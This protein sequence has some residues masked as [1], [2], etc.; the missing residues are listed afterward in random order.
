MVLLIDDKPD[1][2]AFAVTVD[3]VARSY[4][5]GISALQERRWDLLLLDH[6]LG[7]FDEQG[8][9]YTGHSIATW[10]EENPRYLPL[11]VVAVSRNPIGGDRI[12]AAIESARRR[13]RSEDIDTEGPLGV[14]V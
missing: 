1:S 10:L 5:E 2:K 9:E 4:Q 13:A 14:E 7:E 12:R 11:E 3:R 6:D 8:K